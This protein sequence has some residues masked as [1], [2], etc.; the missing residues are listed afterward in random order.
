MCYLGTFVGPSVQGN[1]L[2][3]FD[4]VH[5]PVPEGHENGLGTHVHFFNAESALNLHLCPL[6]GRPRIT[7]TINA[8]VLWVAKPGRSLGGLSREKLTRVFKN[9]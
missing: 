7:R 5:G 2:E 3:T 6:W 4:V 9:G 8:D 1:V